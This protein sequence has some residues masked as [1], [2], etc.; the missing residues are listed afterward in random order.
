MATREL[1]EATSWFRT[2]SSGRRLVA[3]VTVISSR[4]PG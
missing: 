3:A 4:S 1:V 2:F